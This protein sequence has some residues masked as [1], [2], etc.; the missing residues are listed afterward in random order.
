VKKH[1]KPSFYYILE[2]G[3][4]KLKKLVSGGGFAYYS[5]ETCFSIKL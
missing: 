3:L 5:Y 4:Y 2:F 1:S